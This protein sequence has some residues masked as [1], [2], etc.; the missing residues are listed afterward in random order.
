MDVWRKEGVYGGRLVMVGFGC[1][2]QATLPLLLRHIDM[3]PAQVL[4]VDPDDAAAATARAYGATFLKQ[5]L[6]ARNVRSCL[7]PLLGA[8]DFLLNLAVDVSSTAMI[9]F[10]SLSTL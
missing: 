4:I 1:V 10:F 5:G 3:K 6:D 9:A 2:G 7:E 8:G